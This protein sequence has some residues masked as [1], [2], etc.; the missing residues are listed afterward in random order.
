MIGQSPS[1]SFSGKSEIGVGWLRF[2]CDVDD[3]GTIVKYLLDYFNCGLIDRRKGWNGYLQS[4]TGAY[5]II[6]ALTPRLTQQQRD[7]L[8]IKKS[9]NEGYLTCDIPQAALDALP[10]EKLMSF[11]LD[12]FAIEK[13]K[14]TRI[15]LY[16]DD[17]SKRIAPS[18]VKRQVL[19]REVAC[20]RYQTMKS[21][22][23]F[24]LG[25]LKSNG[26]TVYFG[27][28][29]SNKQIRYYDK[30]AESGGEKKCYRL[31]GQF[32]A[33]KAES[34][35]NWFAQE[36]GYVL[37]THSHAEAAA[38]IAQLYKRVLLASID[39]RDVRRFPPDQRLPDNWAARSPRADWYDFLIGQIEKA[40]L[41]TN[42]VAPSLSRTVKW[43]RSQVMPALALVRQVYRNWS[44]PWNQWVTR[45]MEDAEK[46]WGDRHYLM[47][48]DAKMRSP[49]WT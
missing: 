38:A 20:P 18:E 43:L 42:R 28:P 22:E 7:E 36:F 15:D 12:L 19:A 25:N 48:L 16:L 9:P 14:L 45:E 35:Y 2:T 34:I 23:Q 21:Y 46:R 37:D 5:S 3:Y 10:S 4:L 1:T 39:F 44:L 49:A 13:L 41:V 33:D 29:Q 40:V 8:G 6:V 24:T 11:W 47:L 31:E 27:S 26:E 17:Y 30:E 32:S